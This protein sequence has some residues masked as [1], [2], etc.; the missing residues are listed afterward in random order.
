MI[1]AS[2]V[3]VPQWVLPF[4]N[5]M[6]DGHVIG[7]LQWRFTVDKG[8]VCNMEIVTLKQGPFAS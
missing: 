6:V 7:V 1:Q 8:T 4:E 5:G 3:G 2:V